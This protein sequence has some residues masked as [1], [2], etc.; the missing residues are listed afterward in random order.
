M[1]ESACPCIAITRRTRVC[2]G[3]ASGREDDDIHLIRAGICREQKAPS[4]RREGWGGFIKPL[5]LRHLPLSGETNQLSDTFLEMDVDT[6][7]LEK[8]FEDADDLFAIITDREDTSVR[9]LLERD[10]V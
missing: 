8:F 5:R 7:M 10:A 1:S 6:C 3:V 4:L 2:V 9:F